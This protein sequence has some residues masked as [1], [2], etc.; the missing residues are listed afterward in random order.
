MSDIGNIHNPLDVITLKTE[1]FFQN[2]LHNIASKVADMRIVIYG[3][4][5]GIHAYLALNIRYKF[6]NLLSQ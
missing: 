6:F 2:I 5:T 3:G 4:S 1:L